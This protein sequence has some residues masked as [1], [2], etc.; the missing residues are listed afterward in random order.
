M[1]LGLVRPGA[2]MAFGHLTASLCLW[3]R[4]RVA[5]ARRLTEVLGGSLRHMAS[6]EIRQGQAGGQE[7][8]F[9][10]E[11]SLAM[12]QAAQRCCTIAM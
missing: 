10:Q 2:E 5:R 7:K 9:P 4:D 3:G 12:G 8:P 6:A 11:E 1:G